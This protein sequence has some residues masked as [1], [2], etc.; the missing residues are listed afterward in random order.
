LQ[1]HINN[2]HGPAEDPLSPA[3]EPSLVAGEAGAAAAGGGGAGAAG[4]A[5]ARG[6]RRNGS[7]DSEEGF[8]GRDSLGQIDAAQPPPGSEASQRSPEHA[9]RAQSDGE[10]LVIQTDATTGSQR[11]MAVES[12]ALVEGSLTPSSASAI[13]STP[14]AVDSMDASL[15]WADDTSQGPMTTTS[16]TDPALMSQPS[17]RSSVSVP[18]HRRNWTLP[19]LPEVLAKGSPVSQERGVRLKPIVRERPAERQGV[20]PAGGQAMRALPGV[21]QIIQKPGPEEMEDVRKS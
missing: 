14:P 17:L 9:N 11:H 4:V 20:A 5:G 15:L 6:R 19:P 16:T 21:Q 3:I 10:G 1:R 12:L 18:Q 7:E 13:A 2:E 8:N